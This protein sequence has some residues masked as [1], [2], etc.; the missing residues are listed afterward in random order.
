MIQSNDRKSAK[1]MEKMT[2]P[3]AATQTIVALEKEISMNGQ[4]KSAF[5]NTNVYS[6]L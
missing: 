2:T 5:A 6:M 3:N 1:I 4:L